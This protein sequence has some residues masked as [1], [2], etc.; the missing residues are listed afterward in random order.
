MGEKRLKNK[1]FFGGGI[2]HIIEKQHAA[3]RF[4]I[5]INQRANVVVFGDEYP[6]FEN[7][8]RQKQFIAGVNRALGRISHIVACNPHCAN[9]LRH[10]VGIGKNTQATQR[11]W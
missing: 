4:R 3:V 11:R 7:G 9:R 2:P 5:A 10:D 6:P 8:L 1:I